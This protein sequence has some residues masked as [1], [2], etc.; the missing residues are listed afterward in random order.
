[1]A[2]EAQLLANREN[3]AASTGPVTPQGKS[4][5]SRNAVTSGLFSATGFL[6]PDERD[7]YSEFRAAYEAD[8]APAG[9]I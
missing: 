6:Q 3:A 1:M 5:V 8:L 9:A 7:I 2:T 4:R